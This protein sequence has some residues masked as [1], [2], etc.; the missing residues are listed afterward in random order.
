MTFSSRE[1]GKFLGTAFAYRKC[2]HADAARGN[3]RKSGRET[4][5]RT[6]DGNSDPRQ[7]ELVRE[8]KNPEAVFA[9]TRSGR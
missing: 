1:N 3:R 9:K 2:P 5:Y 6:V 8:S 7:H 4:G